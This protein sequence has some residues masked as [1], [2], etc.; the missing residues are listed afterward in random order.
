MWEATIA[1]YLHEKRI[2][3]L[4]ARRAFAYSAPIGEHFLNR[5]FL[6]WAEAGEPVFEDY[7]YVEAFLDGNSCQE[8]LFFTLARAVEELDRKV[9]LG[10]AWAYKNLFT[11]RHQHYPFSNS[12][13]AWFFQ[14]DGHVDGNSRTINLSHAKKYGKWGPFVS[15][16]GTVY[17]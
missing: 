11:V 15:F 14:K 13:L 1:S 6:E 7:C 12:I 8:F 10:N 5:K 4:A 17:R 3:G 16:A 2:K 9:G